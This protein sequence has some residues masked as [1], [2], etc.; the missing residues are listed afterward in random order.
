MKLV[1]EDQKERVLPPVS[2]LA[3]EGQSWPEIAAVSQE[4][5]TEVSEV[6]V[7]DSRNPDH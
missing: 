4:L 1:L 2:K 5:G 7:R 3:I 6:A